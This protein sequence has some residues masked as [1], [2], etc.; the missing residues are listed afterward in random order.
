MIDKGINKAP[1]QARHKFALTAYSDV[2]ME[3]QQQNMILRGESLYTFAPFLYPIL[4]IATGGRAETFVLQ[5]AITIRIPC[6]EIFTN[7]CICPLT[8]PSSAFTLTA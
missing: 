4:G 2:R 6:K 8:I 1:N 7:K 3:L 5:N